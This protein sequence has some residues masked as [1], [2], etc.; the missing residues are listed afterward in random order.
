[1]E[2]AS[3]DFGTPSGEVPINVPAVNLSGYKNVGSLSPNSVIDITVGIPLKNEALLDSMVQQVSDPGSSSYRHFITQQLAEQLF[4]PASQYSTLVQTLTGDGFGIQLTS[5]DSSIVARG[6]V[7]Q[8][9]RYLGLSVDAYSN[10]TSMYY[11]AEG[12]PAI[13]GAYFYASNVTAVLYAHPNDLVTRH[14]VTTIAKAGGGKTDQ[15]AAYEAFPAT[16]LQTVYNA[17]A[18]LNRGYDG[19]GATIGILDFCGDPYI[20]DQLET[21]DSYFNLT[22]PPSFTVSPIGDYVPIIGVI[23]GWA[24]EIS[25]DV[26]VS[27]AMAPGANMVLYIANNNLDLAPVIADIVQQHAVNDLSMSFGTPESLN[28]QSN[29]ND[30]AM[31][32]LFTDEYFALGSLTGMTFLAST[33]DTG[34]SGY[35]GGPEGT[36]GYPSTSPF[37]TAVGATATYFTYTAEGSVQSFYQTAWSNYGFIPDMINYGGS[38][39]GVSIQEPKPWYQNVTTPAGYPDGRMVPDLALDGSGNPGVLVV[40]PGDLLE[41]TG[42]TSE[43]VQLLGG[44]LALIISYT[45]KP[46]GLLNPTLYALGSNPTY[47]TPITFGYN[48]P[49]SATTGYNL[50]T[51]LGVPNIG[52]LATLQMPVANHLEIGVTTSNWTVTATNTDYSEPAAFQ[53]FV[54]NQTIDIEASINASNGTPLN[55]GSGPFEAE[56]ET[57]D[58]ILNT[59]TLHNN[60]TAGIWNGSLVVP[61]DAQGISFIQVNGSSG[62]VSGQGFTEIFTGYVLAFLNLDPVSPYSTAIGIP[63][64]A[65]IT[66]LNGASITTGSFGV[67]LDRYSMLDNKYMSYPPTDLEYNATSKCWDGT[68]SGNYPVGPAIIEG[69]NASGDL[70]FNNGVS[71]QSFIIIPEMVVEPGCAA[72][73]QEIEIYGTLGSP[74]YLPNITDS[75]TGDTFFNSIEY[76]SNLTA[77]LVDPLGQVIEWGYILQDPLEPTLYAALMP[78][79]EDIASGLYTILLNSS[80][81]SYNLASNVSGAYY[82][83]I[84]VSTGESVPSVALASIPA[85]E[86]QFVTIF[87]DITDPGGHEVTAGMYTAAVYTEDLAGDVS[88][89]TTEYVGIPLNYDSTLGKWTATFIL[90]SPEDP[91]PGGIEI[92]PQGYSGFFNIFISGISANG[93]PTTSD[94]SNQYSFFVQPEEYTLPNITFINPVSGQSVNNTISVTVQVT[95]TTVV[96]VD[97]YIDNTYLKSFYTGGVLTLTLDTANL[98]DGVHI[99]SVVAGQADGEINEAQVYFT[100]N[101]K[102]ASLESQ[103]P[104]LGNEITTSLVLASLALGVAACFA[105]AWLV[106]YFRNKTGKPPALKNM[107]RTYG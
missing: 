42:G 104:G 91:S 14:D 36:V 35:S 94:P 4:Y 95:G 16:D 17:T 77:S 1:L 50:V 31:N 39:G 65:S 54:V 105:V 80:Y 93:V 55:T 74:E 100:V 79:P 11:S 61:A 26:E 12:T 18:L 29:E 41:A 40:M 58:G 30:L 9:E 49:W 86:G 88:D 10:G 46:L 60:G 71:L 56:L 83:Q 70:V 52:E 38:T 43:S 19:A 90:P 67:M 22:D 20:N 59:T 73:G 2:K 85:V 63:I 81:Y 53:E 24:E 44:L 103:P 62:S 5:L 8:V 98:S 68:I 33:G 87:A 101:N 78:I 7:A 47:F 102:L 27:H 25:L 13:G 84:Y 64:N 45:G 48:I 34:G 3:A 69:V 28:Q 32:T 82:G 21:F 72:P 57:V 97:F 96:E 75:A 89:I 92:G 51:G 99:I 6:T 76:A 23:N 66:E 37:V 15:S 106:V 107:Y